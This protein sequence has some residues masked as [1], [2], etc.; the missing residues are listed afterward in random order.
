[1]E[2]YATA[3]ISLTGGAEI[4]LACSWKLQAGQDAVIE[5]T[6]YGTHG[7]VSLRNTG[8]SFYHFVCE[9][10]T[11]TSRRTLSQESDEWGGRA[12]IEWVRALAE[13]ST[14]DPLIE[15]IVE[16]AAVLDRIYG[17]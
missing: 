15:S 4:R 13:G 12:A 3:N 10:Y 11:G 9:R 8:G 2:D 14:Y 16:V 1:V 7:A 5:A 17:R 6:F